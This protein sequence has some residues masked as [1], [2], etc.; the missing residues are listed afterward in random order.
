MLHN[1]LH[2]IMFSVVVSCHP[3]SSDLNSASCSNTGIKGSSIIGRGSLLH[4]EDKDI[5]KV[6]LYVQRSGLETWALDQNV[7]MT[8]KSLENVMKFEYSGTTIRN[9]KS[10][11]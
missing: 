4:S 8:S 5:G 10:F 7:E 6:K 3:L 1:Q 11:S 2:E 9:K